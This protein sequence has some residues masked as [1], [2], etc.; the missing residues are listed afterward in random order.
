MTVPHIHHIL[1]FKLE[2]HY[3]S[4]QVDNFS[5]NRVAVLN[6]TRFRKETVVVLLLTKDLL[7]CT[8]GFSPVWTDIHCV[9]LPCSLA[10]HFLF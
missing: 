1:G 9:P 7:C 3:S 4:V 6:L 10:P 5:L 2:I 8:F